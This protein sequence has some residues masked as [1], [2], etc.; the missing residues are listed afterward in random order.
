MLSY[1]VFFLLTILPVV[2]YNNDLSFQGIAS[3]Q[4]I[5]NIIGFFPMFIAFFIGVLGDTNRAP[6]DLAEAESELVSG[7]NVEY[8][9]LLFTLYFLGEYLNIL[10]LSTVLIIIFM[11]TDFFNISTYLPLLNQ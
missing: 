11:G 5:P 9:G 2:S 3:T 7:F 4:Y 8:S 10:L 6:L 1:E